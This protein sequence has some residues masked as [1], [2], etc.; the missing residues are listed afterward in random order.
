MIEKYTQAC[1][2]DATSVGPY[3]RVLSSHWRGQIISITEY[4]LGR[5]EHAWR[6]LENPDVSLTSVRSTECI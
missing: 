4:A 2:P 1:R 5:S 3:F 6:G